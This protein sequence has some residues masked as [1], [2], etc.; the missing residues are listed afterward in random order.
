ML[1]PAFLFCVTNIMHCGVWMACV[2]PQ[3]ENAYNAF[4]TATKQPYALLFTMFNVSLQESYCP[5]HIL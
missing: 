1:A 2:V 4:F 3:T 5:V